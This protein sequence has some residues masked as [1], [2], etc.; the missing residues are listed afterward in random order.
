[1]RLIRGVLEH[2]KILTK[3]RTEIHFSIFIENLVEILN[4][5][6]DLIMKMKNEKKSKFYFILKGKLNIP[7]D[8]Q[9]LESVYG[10]YNSEN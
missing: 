4:L 5:F 9:I 3:K 10:N 2:R 1:M 8:P 6:F 7:F